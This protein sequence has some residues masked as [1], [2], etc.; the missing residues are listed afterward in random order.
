MLFR[1]DYARPPEPKPGRWN[2]LI[3][4]FVLMWA[5]GL[6]CHNAAA[7]SEAFGGLLLLV[8]LPACPFGTLSLMV[9]GDSPL[10]MTARAMLLLLPWPACGAALTW[11][12]WRG[13][14]QRVALTACVLV[15]VHTAA[16]IA[17][18]VVM[19]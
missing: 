4:S 5:T 14:R 8:L 7:L 17:V 16:I 13:D 19:R 12:G 15:L 1:S 9:R 3:L 10:E 11:A 18:I 6:L 2:W